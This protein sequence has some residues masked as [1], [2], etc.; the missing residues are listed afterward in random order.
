[1]CKT[2]HQHASANG[3]E[4]C[5]NKFNKFTMPEHEDIENFVKAI[6]LHV[7]VHGITEGPL[8]CMGDPSLPLLELSN[9]GSVDGA[10]KCVSHFRLIWR[11]SGSSDQS[12]ALL[13]EAWSCSVQNDIMTKEFCG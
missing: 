11:K 1:M 3:M 6:G 5:M 13:K 9:V 7:A 4:E 10:G 2:Y 8:Q 12:T